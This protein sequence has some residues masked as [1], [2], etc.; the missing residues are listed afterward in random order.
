MALSAMEDAVGLKVAVRKESIYLEIF[1]VHMKNTTGHREN[2]VLRTLFK[3]PPW[4]RF[5][6]G[7]EQMEL[8]PRLQ[9][10]GWHD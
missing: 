8:N 4:A 1:A 9:C 3:A 2:V 10:M 5:G 7:H 6:G